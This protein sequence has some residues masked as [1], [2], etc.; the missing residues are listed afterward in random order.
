MVMVLLV[1]QRGL[2]YCAR[3]DG[4]VV[5][6]AMI[7]YPKQ[8]G[9]GL[10]QMCEICS[11]NTCVVETASRERERSVDIANKEVVKWR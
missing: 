1:T 11:A 8:V 4:D 9:I 2:L 3:F 6:F 7:I 5:A 10:V